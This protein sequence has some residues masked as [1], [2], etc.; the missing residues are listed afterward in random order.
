[1]EKPEGINNVF[2]EKVP[3][4]GNENMKEILVPEEETQSNSKNWAKEGQV[5]I[6]MKRKRSAEECVLKYDRLLD[7]LEKEILEGFK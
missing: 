3:V 7:E 4:L 1:M 6:E 5:K 2:E